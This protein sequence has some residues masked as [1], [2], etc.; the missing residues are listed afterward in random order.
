MLGC[1]GGPCF[2]KCLIAKFLA[3]PFQNPSGQEIARA[4]RADT[5]T[6]CPTPRSFKSFLRRSPNAIEKWKN[7]STGNKKSFAELVRNLKVCWW[8][9]LLKLLKCVFQEYPP[10]FKY[11]TLKA[12]TWRPQNKAPHT[13]GPHQSFQST[14]KPMIFH[15]FLMKS[16]TIQNGKPK[17]NPKR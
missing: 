9:N 7:A 5:Q 16:H 13:F 3:K 15:I 12:P 14:H 11:F 17:T 1:A 4:M 10:K 2:A 8:N 6:S